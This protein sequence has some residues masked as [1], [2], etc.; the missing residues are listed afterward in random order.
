MTNEEL[1][2]FA[3]KR[4]RE[5][6][7]IAYTETCGFIIIAINGPTDYVDIQAVNLPLESAYSVMAQ[8]AE[9]RPS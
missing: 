6:Q 2:A 5:M 8:I 1:R 4:A 7:N 3:E 9:R